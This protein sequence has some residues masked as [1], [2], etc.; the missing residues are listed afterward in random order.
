[1]QSDV[2]SSGTPHS[3][4]AYCSLALM[5]A[6]FGLAA[7]QGSALENPPWLDESHCIGVHALSRPFSGSSGSFPRA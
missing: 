4:L 6:A 1:M 7:I 3:A 2:G 5:S